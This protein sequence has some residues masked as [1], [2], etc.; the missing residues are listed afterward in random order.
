MSRQIFHRAAG[1]LVLLLGVLYGQAQP[2]VR[3][4]VVADKD[5]ILIGEP[6]KLTLE[7]EIP[8]TEP[9]RF[10]RLDSLGA[11]E[12]VN[13]GRIDT[14]N[15][16][17]GTRLRQI[18]TITSFD[19]GSLVIPA[20]PLGDSLL[21]DTLPVEVSY[22]PFDPGK[23]YHDIKDILPAEEPKNEPQ[24]WWWWVAAGS[25]LA[26]VIVYF[27]ARGKKTPPPAAPVIP[28]DPFK[29]AMQQLEELE[30][31]RPSKKEYYSRAVDIFRVY[32]DQR[33]GIHSQQQTTDDLVNQLRSI[34]LPETLYTNLSRSLRLSDFVKFARFEPT[35]QDDQDLMQVIRETIRTLEGMN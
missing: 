6:I 4:S 5:R 24:R 29:T 1:I 33:K 30:A 26:L 21:S 13:A 23:P 14:S 15:T 7:A 9:I 17:N 18:L 20:L 31:Q 3:I 28:Q 8:E 27:I 25:V 10:F 32:A 22:T 19:S 2:G 34:G 12:I 11:F 35:V 16:G